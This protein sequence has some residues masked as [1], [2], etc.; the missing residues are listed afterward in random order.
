MGITNPSPA[1]LKAMLI[2][3]SRSLGAQYDFNVNTEVANEQGWG[4]PNIT[5]SIPLS[6][7]NGIT[8]T[9]ASMLLIDQSPSNALA[10][11]QYQTYTINCGDTNAAQVYPLRITLVWTDPPGDPAAGVALVNNLDL[12]VVDATGT[13]IY[14]GN[15]FLGGDIFTEASSTNTL[16]AGESDNAVQNIYVANGVVNFTSAGDS[17]NNVQNVYIN[18]ANVPITFPLTVTI[19]G[20]RVNVNAVPGQTNNIIQDYALVISSDDPALTKPLTIFSSQFGAT[21]VT[22]VTVA[23]NGV[24]LLHQRVGANEPNLYMSNQLLALTNGNSSQWHFFIFTNDQFIGTTNATNVA[25]ATFL[26]PN[27]SIPRNSSADI[28]LYVSTNSAVDQ[29]D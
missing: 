10:T 20:T 18:P 8:S 3:G 19:S 21:N 11:G 23:S 14:I 12:T 5:N 29:L 28:D 9:N 17:I 27:L 2:N 7:S 16:P 24:P 1:L 4:L 25:F 26:P 6:L 15:D 13:N 22:L